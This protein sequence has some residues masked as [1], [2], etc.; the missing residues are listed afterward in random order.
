MRTW[1]L[2]AL[3]LGP[4]VPAA[5]APN[6]YQVQSVTDVPGLKVGDMLDRN[7][8]VKIPANA[9]LRLIDRTGGSVRTR[10]CGGPH[11]GPV[12]ACPKPAGSFQGGETV[13]GMR[14][15]GPMPQG[16]GQKK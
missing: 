12:G 2:I 15:V 5:A 3:C 1:L 4:A 8:R 13:G 14:G 16:E 9:R 10:D 6:D 11:D 7:T